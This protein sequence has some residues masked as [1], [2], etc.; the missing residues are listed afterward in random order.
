MLHYV[1]STIMHCNIH[2]LLTSVVPLFG[3]KTAENINMRKIP[4]FSAVTVNIYLTDNTSSPGDSIVIRLSDGLVGVSADP[5]HYSLMLTQH[6]AYAWN[7][8]RIQREDNCLHS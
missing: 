5:M 7:L 6:S 2:N 1:G 4:A 8:C 3:I